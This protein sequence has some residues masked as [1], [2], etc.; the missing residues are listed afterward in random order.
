MDK[1]LYITLEEPINGKNTGVIKKIK[2]QCFVLNEKHFEVFLS[3]YGVDN[4]YI[5]MKNNTVIS[6][7]KINKNIFTNKYIFGFIFDFIMRN[8]INKIYVRRFRATPL[9]IRFFNKL[10]K[11]GVKIF[12]EIPTYPYDGEVKSIKSKLG[13]I[14]DKIFRKEYKKYISKVVT[15]SEDEFIFGIKCINISNGIDKKDIIHDKNSFKSK[16]VYECISVSSMC[17]WHGIDRF[18]NGIKKNHNIIFHIV[19]PKN[20]YYNDLYNIVKNKGLEDKVIFHGFLDHEQLKA[21]YKKCHIAIGSL[22]RHRSGIENLS[23][24][25]NREYIAK[26]L[27][28]VYSEND[29]DFDNEGFVFKV[30]ADESYVEIDDLLAWY[31]NLSISSE[32]MTNIANKFTWDEQMKLVIDELKNA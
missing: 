15:Y 8:N 1:L 5:I 10:K 6:S 25:K 32:Y 21:I 30:T 13:L 29:R 7:K 3:G 9:S 23:S 18:L 16:H 14:V 31:G 2:S 17:H 19:G 27:P 28:I 12:I 24:L 26:G 20:L 4:D 22:G 11:K